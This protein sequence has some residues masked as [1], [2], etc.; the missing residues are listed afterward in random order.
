[1]IVMPQGQ[2]DSFIWSCRPIVGLSFPRGK[3][4]L[5]AYYGSLRHCQCAIRQRTLQLQYFVDGRIHPQIQ[6]SGSGQD[7]RHGFRV[8]DAAFPTGHGG[9]GAK[10]VIRRFTILPL[11][12]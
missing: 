2:R 6:F 12:H 5:A 3:T 7:D 8:K 1:M 4:T 10:Q 9:Q 11:T